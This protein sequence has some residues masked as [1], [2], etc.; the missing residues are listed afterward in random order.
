MDFYRNSFIRKWHNS[1]H[2][3]L[4]SIRIRLKNHSVAIKK[5][6]ESGWR[7][8]EAP[9]FNHLRGMSPYIKFWKKTLLTR[10]GM[11]NN[12]RNKWI[13]KSWSAISISGSSRCVDFL[14]KFLANENVFL[15][16]HYSYFFICI[17]RFLNFALFIH[18]N[19]Q[20]MSSGQ[21][22]SGQKFPKKIVF[23]FFARIQLSENNTNLLIGFS[24]SYRYGI[25]LKIIVAL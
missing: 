10:I 3:L 13:L 5:F 22:R 9:I 1:T 12:W 6:Q 4:R 2:R 23:L 17:D 19:L 15:E 7:K 25:W 18:L 8:P 11:F 16:S 20:N 14:L 21:V 24:G